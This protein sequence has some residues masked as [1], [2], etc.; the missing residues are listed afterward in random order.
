MSIKE[1]YTAFC[2]GFTAYRQEH[3]W[4]RIILN[5][6]MVVTLLFMI[7]MLFLDNNNIGV[8]FHTRKTLREQDKQIEYLNGEIRKA[9]SRLNHLT[10]RKDSLEQFARE[11]Y[12]FHEDD[13]DV[14]IVK[15]V[16]HE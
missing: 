5:K 10:S 16:N 7:W 4:L 8:W 12:L 9:E 13:E 11:E 3:A 6:Y 14:Y 1:K 15:Q 2:Q